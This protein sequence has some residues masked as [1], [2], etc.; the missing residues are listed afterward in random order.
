MGSNL[1]VQHSTESPRHPSILHR[2][3]VAAVCALNNMHIHSLFVHIRSRI[4][5]IPASVQCTC[6]QT[7]SPMHFGHFEGLVH[8]R[9]CTRDISFDGPGSGGVHKCLLTFEALHPFDSGQKDKKA[10]K[11]ERQTVF[12][13]VISGQFYTLAMFFTHRGNTQI[14]PSM[15]E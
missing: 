12:N 3:H 8:F 4:S 6:Y 7:P 9:H 5:Q 13:I 15:R 11:D 1:T 14:C 10:Q 2:I